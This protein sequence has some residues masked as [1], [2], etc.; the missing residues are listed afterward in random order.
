MST[1]LVFEKK[2]FENKLNPDLVKIN[3]DSVGRCLVTKALIFC[4]DR[5]QI[6]LKLSTSFQRLITMF[7]PTNITETRVKMNITYDTRTS[8]Y[9]F[10][11]KIVK[12][13]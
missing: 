5:N 13:Y 12:K 3:M 6:L 8:C 10:D 4:Y 1:R 9:E 7:I 2:V 11:Q